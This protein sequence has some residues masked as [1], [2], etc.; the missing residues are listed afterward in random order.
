[1]KNI[2]FINIKYTLVRIQLPIAHQFHEIWFLFPFF[3]EGKC[4]FADDSNL[5][6]VKKEEEFGE[7]MMNMKIAKDEY[8]FVLF[9]EVFFFYL[10]FFLNLKFFEK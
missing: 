9:F 2:Q 10:K 6:H 3:F 8:F 7:L 5:L 4:R 1:M